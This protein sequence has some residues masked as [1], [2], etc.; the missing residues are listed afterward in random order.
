MRTRFDLET[1]QALL[2]EGL[3]FARGDGRGVAG[4][5]AL[6]GLFALLVLLLMLRGTNAPKSPPSPF[7]PVEIVRLGAETTS[8]PQPLQA[9]IPQPVTPH[10]MPHAP[11]SANPPEGTSPTATKPLPDDLETRLRALARLRQPE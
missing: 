4:S 3:A 11:A 5:V 8:P 6:H 1:G 9:K 2:R 10:R 7:V